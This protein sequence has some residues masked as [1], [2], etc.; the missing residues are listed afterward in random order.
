MLVTCDKCG[1]SYQV[2]EAKLPPQGARMKCQNCQHIMII[3]LGGDAADKSSS[4]RAN[5]AAQQPSEAVVAEVSAQDVK[6]EITWKIRHAGLTYTFHDLSSLQDWLKGRASAENVKV[7]KGEDDWKEL[8]DYP[9]VLTTELITKLFPLGDVPKTPKDGESASSASNDT[10]AKA[11]PVIQQPTP[12][13][14]VDFGVVNVS[15]NTLKNVA[16]ARS[17]QN[18][19]KRSTQYGLT[20][21]VVGL[22]TVVI[23]LVCLNF[24]GV[25]EIFSSKQQ[26]PPGSHIEYIDGQEVIVPND[27]FEFADFEKPSGGSQTAD[28][29]SSPDAAAKAVPTEPVVNSSESAIDREEAQKLIDEEIEKRLSQAREQIKK[30]NWPIAQTILLTISNEYPEN[31]EAKELLVKTFRALGQGD[32]ADALDAEVKKLKQA[33]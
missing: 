26:I 20:L 9:E 4:D 16:K 8:G 11:A 14:A 23:V 22:I 2:N 17:E 6:D 13:K 28:S 5:D 24:V 29:P 10:G 21:L 7:A 27:E 30:K 18:K 32:K 3:R 31:I 25:I 12:Q 15:K 19:Q 33:N 1:K